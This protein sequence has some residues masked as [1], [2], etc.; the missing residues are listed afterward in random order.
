MQNSIGSIAIIDPIGDFGIGGYTYELAEGIAANGIKVD[1][2]TAELSQAAAMQL[3][4]HHAIFPV[5]GS[6]LFRQR[7]ELAPKKQQTR[8]AGTRGA[9][10][11]IVVPR[12]RSLRDSV[13]GLLLSLELA[14]HLKRQRYDLVWTQW[15]QMD[16]YGTRFW[17]ACK[18]FG[19]RTAHTVHNVLPH[20]EGEGDREAV[21]KVY[22]R[23]DALAVHSEYSRRELLNLYPECARKV[24][25]MRHGLYT[26]FPRLVQARGK[27]RK[28]L[29]IPES[30]ALFLFLGSVRPYKNIDAVLEA[31]RKMNDRNLTLIVAGRE[32]KYPDMVPGDPLG[33]ARRIA[34]ALGISEKVRF[35]PGLLGIEETAELFESSDALLLPYSKSYGSGALLLGMTYGIHIVATRAGGM[36]EYLSEYPRS[37]II[38]S[39]DAACVERG[40]VQAMGLVA[41]DASHIDIRSHELE[42]RVIAEAALQQLNSM[43]LGS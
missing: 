13:A 11:P 19:L 31:M 8:Q 41:Q 33:R 1:V 28:K 35:L 42:W 39:A 23:S 12:R 7:R 25:L 16:R 34:S 40:M 29:D 14:L 32:S 15:P 36:D 4:R 43:G 37:T 18:A 2:Y 9:V 21:G 22:N 27:I 30:E 38:D 17:P 24:F 26:T 10:S 6:F 5:L 20:E 3:P